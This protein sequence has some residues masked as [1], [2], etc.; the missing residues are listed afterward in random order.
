MLF[1]FEMYFASFTILLVEGSSETV[2]FT[3]VSNHIFRSREVRKYIN[4]KGHLFLKIFKIEF[5]FRKYKKKKSKNIWICCN[6]LPLLR[7]E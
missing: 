2:L 1:S 6:K 3:R 4:F 7:R 5:K